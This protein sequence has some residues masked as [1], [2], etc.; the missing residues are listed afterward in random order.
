MSL[1]VLD[2]GPLTDVVAFLM[3]VDKLKSVK[4]RSKVIGTDCQEDSAEHS[5]HFAL[6]AMSLAP[7]AGEDVDIQRVIQ[8]ALIHDIVEVD[9]GDVL[10]YDLQGRADAHDRE[11]AAAIRL[12]GL[13]PEP[14]RSLF[15]QLWLEYEASKTPDARFALL[16][17]RLMPVLMNLHNGGQSWVEHGIRLEQV[18]SR[19][20][21]ISEVYPE[22]WGYL[23]HHLEVAKSKGWLK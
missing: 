10:V 22:L 12:F 16:I 15:H 13:L 6:A 3:E 9:A 5:W 4:R 1:A 11:V 7:Y 2:F 18:L 23:S 20:A 8:M 14:Q 21:F 19:N 17:D